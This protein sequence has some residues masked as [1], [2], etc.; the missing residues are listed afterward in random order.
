MDN[1]Y[2][3]MIIG[4]VMN[5]EQSSDKNKW[6]CRMLQISGLKVW[7]KTFEM[8]FKRFIFS[9]CPV[10]MKTDDVTMRT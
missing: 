5:I 10:L 1:D 2:E 3:M 6:D 9:Q 4:L 7:S 8:P